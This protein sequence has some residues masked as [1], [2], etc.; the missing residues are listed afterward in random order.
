MRKRAVI[1]A[2]GLGLIT[3]GVV[4]TL[5]VPLHTLLMAMFTRFG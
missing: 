2:V 5:F 4:H 1:F 3:L